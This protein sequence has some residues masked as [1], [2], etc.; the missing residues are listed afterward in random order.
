[1]TAA[2]N[3][4]LPALVL[5]AAGDVVVLTRWWLTGRP[6]W[7]VGA[8][9]RPPVWDSGVDVH[10]VST[11]IASLALVAGT[12][13]AYRGV[14]KLRTTEQPLRHP[15]STTETDHVFRASSTA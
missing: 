9:V 3:S 6:E 2:A 11:A 1:L 8:T 10:F 7:Q 14:R 4:I 13:A 15:P 5:H 12:A